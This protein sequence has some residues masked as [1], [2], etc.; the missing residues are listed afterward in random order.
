MTSI[1][2]TTL[3]AIYGAAV[4]TA[5]F[6]LSLHLARRD[7]GVLRVFAGPDDPARR[8]VHPV[9]DGQPR[10][11]VHVQ[12]IGRRPM[13]IDG[14]WYT[15]WSSGTVQH[16]LTDRYDKGTEVLREGE[17]L[18]YDLSFAHVTPADVSSIVVQTQDG[19]SW[20]G[21][22]DERTRPIKWNQP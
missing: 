17:S 14:I 11:L 12:N 7:R 16:L 13:S 1:S 15:K 10:F 2:P 8:E 18:V 20:K 4:G 6:L 5:G 9:S 21:N 19:R 3:F 22:Y